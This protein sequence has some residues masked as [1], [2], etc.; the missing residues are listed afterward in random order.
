M[1]TRTLILFLISIFVGVQNAVAQD[2]PAEILKKADEIR[3]PGISY[4]MKV[5][6]KS[7]GSENEPSIY[8]VYLK[9]NS[10]TLV[11]ALAPARDKG[12]NML[13]IDEDMWAYVPNLKRAVRVSLNQKLSGQTANGDIS[14]T[15][16]TGDYTPTLESSDA[17][18]WVLYL[19]ADK[20]G[21]TYDRIRVWVQKGS[22]RPEKA[23]YLSLN[24]KVLK[25]VEYK[26]FKGMAGAERP[27]EIHI[28]DALNETEKSVI[29]IQS[30][31]LKEHPD[32]LFNQNNLK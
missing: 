23:E 7:T 27:S 10:K 30:M 18:Y 16:W 12:R 5:E 9:G 17:K 2:N 24:D 32:S 25:K 14:R 1:T 8:E 31:T 21:L 11:K 3:N 4:F 6:V 20:K 26:A 29:A 13:M 15:R 22:Y 19:K 28:Q